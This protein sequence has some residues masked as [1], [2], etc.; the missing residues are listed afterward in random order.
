MATLLLHRQASNITS[1]FD[2]ILSVYGPVPYESQM[3]EYRLYQHLSLSAMAKDKRRFGSSGS[4]RVERNHHTVLVSDAHIV[5]TSQWCST[6]DDSILIL[7]KNH[8]H[9]YPMTINTHSDFA[10]L[11]LIGLDDQWNNDNQDD[12]DHEGS[13]DERHFEVFPPHLILQFTRTL[14]EDS[15]LLVELITFFCEIFGLL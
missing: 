15:C 2:A 4:L 6:C 11:I 10:N 12:P 14:L 3:I 7:Y 9:K 13:Q 1:T 8:T 5:R